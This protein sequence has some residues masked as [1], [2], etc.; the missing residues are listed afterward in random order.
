MSPDG[1]V[2]RLFVGTYLS[3]QQQE[4][5]GTLSERKLELEKDLNCRV[6]LVKQHKLHL[7]WLFLGD[8]EAQRVP[9]ICQKLKTVLLSTKEM[10]LIYK[11]MQLWP[12]VKK[13][14][15]IVLTPEKVPAEV[16]NLAAAIFSELAPCV[17]KIGHREYH[18]HIT[19]ARLQREDF[20]A[21]SLKIP[22]W[23][24]HDCCLPIT[25]QIARIELIQSELGK[26]ADEYQTLF[27]LDLH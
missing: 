7:T 3:P 10:S 19:L 20:E 18:P 9:E 22:D 4:S 5:L 15:M 16:H 23:F 6:R 25:H 17:K 8:V 14:R 26:Q 12:S 24:M 2:K 13:A 11:Q 21:A 1:Q 27:S